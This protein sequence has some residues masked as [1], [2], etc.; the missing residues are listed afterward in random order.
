MLSEGITDRLAVFDG[1]LVRFEPVGSRPSEPFESEIV[2]TSYSIHY[3]KLY[4]IAPTLHVHTDLTVAVNASAE[5]V[6][7][8]KSPD[9]EA[10]RDDDEGGSLRQRIAAFIAD[11]TQH[12]HV[13]EEVV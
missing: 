13:R 1:R 8:L 10:V 11:L 2:I 6:G 5:P 3:T 4:E 12:R 7:E 9:W